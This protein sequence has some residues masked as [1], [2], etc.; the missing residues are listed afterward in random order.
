MVEDLIHKVQGVVRDTVEESVTVVVQGVTKNVVR[1]RSE[2]I[3]EKYSA[4]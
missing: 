4:P 2:E 3:L 1:G